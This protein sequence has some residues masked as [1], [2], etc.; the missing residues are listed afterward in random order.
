MSSKT[1]ARV[2]LATDFGTYLKALRADRG[3]PL[4]VI[5]EGLNLSSQTISNIENNRVS[6]PHPHRVKIWLGLL[7]CSDKYDEAISL[8]RRVKR[9]RSVEYILRDPA[10]E[11]LDRII[12]AYENQTLDVL[13]HALLASIAPREYRPST[14]RT[15]TLKEP[16]KVPK[17]AYAKK[18]RKSKRTEKSP[19]LR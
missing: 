8:L 12:D 6:T 2:P 13:D 1:P 11:H 9:R 4:K 14:R 10:T 3:V 15:E 7:G 17:Q 16:K 5:A 18:T 19:P